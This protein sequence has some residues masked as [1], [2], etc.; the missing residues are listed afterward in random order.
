MKEKK[1]K[2]GVGVDG[3]TILWKHFFKILFLA[4]CSLSIWWLNG[5]LLGCLQETVGLHYNACQTQG[6]PRCRKISQL[7]DMMSQKV[8][9][10]LAAINAAP[11]EDRPDTGRLV[12][13]CWRHLTLQRLQQSLCHS[14]PVT[15]AGVKHQEAW[16][17]GWQGPNQSTQCLDNPPLG[18]CKQPTHSSPS[19]T[20]TDYQQPWSLVDYVQ[21]VTC[22]LAMY[23]Q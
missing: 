12:Q 6:K 3:W 9:T 22:S 8:S 19:P 2:K 7:A 11:T 5:A 13:T 23:N 18:S 21:S 15:V 1:K 17:R 10:R 4:C 14:L 20:C 16:L